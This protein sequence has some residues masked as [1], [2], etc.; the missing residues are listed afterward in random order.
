[1]KEPLERQ[2]SGTD[3]GTDTGTDAD[4]GT[5]TDANPHFDLYIGDRLAMG[6]TAIGRE[7]SRV[8]T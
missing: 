8:L 2:A 1:M 5:G 3:T 7:A 4:T 6:S